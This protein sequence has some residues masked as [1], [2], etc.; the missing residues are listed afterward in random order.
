M[1]DKFDP[2]RSHTHVRMGAPLPRLRSSGRVGHRRSQIVV[3][4]RVSLEYTQPEPPRDVSAPCRC[5]LP[6]DPYAPRHFSPARPQLSPAYEWRPETT[7]LMM[8]RLN[9]IATKPAMLIQ[10]ARVSRQPEVARACR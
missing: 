3:V 5:G 6:P 9:S 10:A 2:P 4:P 7:I 1:I 8:K